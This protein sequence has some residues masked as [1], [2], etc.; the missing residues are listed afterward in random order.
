MYDIKEANLNDNAWALKS[1]HVKR[2]LCKSSGPLLMHT[3]VWWLIWLQ[4]RCWMTT[5]HGIVSSYI[6]TGLMIKLRDCAR[7]QSSKWDD[8]VCEYV[9]EKVENNPAYTLIQINNQLRLDS[10]AK[11]RVSISSL[12]N[13]LPKIRTRSHWEK[14]C[15]CRKRTPIIS[16]MVYG[17]NCAKHQPHLWRWVQLQ[18]VHQAKARQSIVWPTRGDTS[19]GELRTKP[20]CHH[21]HLSGSW[22]IVPWKCYWNSKCHCS[23]KFR[24]RN[25]S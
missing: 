13:M 15:P 17:W 5:V 7:E 24:L 14:H 3:D 22:T 12:L 18:F 6:A 11:S 9:M 8:K 4:R 25:W 21:A 10:S 19:R 2:F 23:N 1:C 16:T 20:R